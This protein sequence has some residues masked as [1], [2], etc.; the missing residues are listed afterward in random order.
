MTISCPHRHAGISVH[1]DTNNPSRFTIFSELNDPRGE[2][3]EVSHVA[4][5]LDYLLCKI[6]VKVDRAVFCSESKNIMPA[7]RFP[8][9]WSAELTPNCFIVRDDCLRLL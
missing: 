4:D 6:L 9:P 1:P 5:V 7:R 2:T 8:P 3:V